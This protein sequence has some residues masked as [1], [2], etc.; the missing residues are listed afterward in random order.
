MGERGGGQTI[1]VRSSFRRQKIGGITVHLTAQRL[2]TLSLTHKNWPPLVKNNKGVG[3]EGMWEHDQS[4]ADYAKKK[5]QGCFSIVLN[6]C[7]CYWV[8]SSPVVEEPVM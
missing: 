8:A 5:V 3:V 2:L 6:A 1:A 7:V 4:K